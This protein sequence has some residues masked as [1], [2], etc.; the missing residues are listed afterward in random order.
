MAQ[1]LNATSVP[2]ARHTAASAVYRIMSVVL[3][4]AVGVQFFLAGAG[5][6]GASSYDAHRKL[7][8]AL[9]AVGFLA[10]LAAILAHEAV[11]FAAVLAGVL[12]LQFVLGRLGEHHQWIGALHGLAALAVAALASVNARRILARRHV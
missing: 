10:L 2:I 3:V 8:A 9:V 12:A 4:A 6:F 11:R 5:A 1:S 7:G